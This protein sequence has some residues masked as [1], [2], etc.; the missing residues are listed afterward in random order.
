V[1]RAALGGMARDG[2]RNGRFVSGNARHQ[3]RW[4][5]RYRPDLGWK[6]SASISPRY[7]VGQRSKVKWSL[8][9]LHLFL[10]L[11]QWLRVSAP[12]DV[13]RRGVRGRWRDRRCEQRRRPATTERFRSRFAEERKG[14]F[15]DIVW[16]GRHALEASK[17]FAMRYRWLTFVPSQTV[18]EMSTRPSRTY[19]FSA[20]QHLTFAL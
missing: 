20:I 13:L 3:G 2:R 9:A 5:H 4:C 14:P 8:L 11:R 6:L 10:P 12:A 18:A 7:F 17:V 1:Q 19:A 15:V 16:R